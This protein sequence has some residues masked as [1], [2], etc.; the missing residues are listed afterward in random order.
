MWFHRQI[1]L[2][3]YFADFVCYPARLVI[4]VDG[5]QHNEPAQQAHD[6]VRTAWLESRGFHVLRFT[7][8]EVLKHL[9]AVVERIDRIAVERAE[10]RGATPPPTIG[11]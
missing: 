5:S 7:N 9:R 6:A 2:G 8:L 10:E 1:A 3:P 4:E 11:A